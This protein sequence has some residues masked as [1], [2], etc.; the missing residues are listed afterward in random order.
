MS[1]PKYKEAGVDIASKDRLIERFQGMMRRT[2]NP[3]VIENPWGFAGL[4]ALKGLKLFDKEYKSPVLVSCADGVGTKL[5]IASMLNKHDTVGIDLVAMSI[6][7]LIVTGATPLFFLDY[8]ATGKIQEQALTEVISGIVKGCEE[9][10]CVLLGGETAEMPGFYSDGEYDMAGFAVGIVERSRIIKGDRIKPGDCVI[11]IASN[12]LHSNGFSLVRDILLR[13]KGYD[14]QEYIPRL[15]CRLW[16]ELLRPTCVYARAIKDVLKHY[17]LRNVIKGIAHITGGGMVQNI[18][19]I[20]PDNC[21]AEIKEGNWPIHPI[22]QFLAQQGGIVKDEMYCVFNMGIGM[23]IIVDPYFSGAII[24][25][26]KS[27]GN[28]AYI[29][30]KI[31]KGKGDVRIQS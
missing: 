4:Y 15:G 29:I 3:F 7:D 1:S 24:K 9:S 14:L 26:L 11:G 8:I 12:G 2:Y 6:N 25:R 23:V 18:S 13:R 21:T 17:R 31:V 10:G 28:P 16:E 5:K 27:Q 20:L 22:F 19:R 30:G